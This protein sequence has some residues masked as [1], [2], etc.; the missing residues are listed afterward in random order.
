MKY[1]NTLLH[2]GDYNPGQ[3]LDSPEILEED[4]RLMKQAG[5]NAMTLAIFDWERLEPE[6]GRYEFDWLEAIIEN[7]YRQGIS[8][9]LATPS[10]ARPGWMAQKYPEVLRVNP[11][12]RRI[13]FSQRHNHCYTSPVYREKVQAMNRA[14]A[15]RFGRHPAV[16]LWHLSNE[17]GGECHCPLCQAAFREWLKKKYGTLEALNHA[18][19]NSFWSHSYS[20]WEQIS[21]P[22][23]GIGEHS[24]HTLVLDWK[25]FV[26]DQTVD[27][28][29]AEAAALR[30]YS[31]DVPITTNMMG[32][33]DGLNYGKFRD[34]CDVISWDNYPHWHNG[35]EGEAASIAMA[36][37]LMRSLKPDR[38]FLMM[39]SSPSA[40]NWE[41]VA[42]LRRPGMHMLSSLQAV[43]HGSDSVQYFQWRKCRGGFEKFHGAVVGHDG[44]AGTRVFRDVQQVGE[45]LGR[46]SQL[47]GARFPARAALLC[48]MEN[49]WIL[50]QIKGLIN[51]QPEKGFL[52]DLKAMYRPFFRNGVN[53]DVVDM[54][55]DLT[56]YQLVAAPMLYL[57]RAGIAGKLRRF[58]EEGGVLV[59]TYWSGVADE[60]D[61]CFLGGAPGQGLDE[62]FGLRAEEIDALYPQDSNQVQLLPGKGLPGM[63][64]SY[65]A[66]ELCEL[67]NLTTAQPL[68]V[69]GQDFY[70]GRPA[71]TVN[72]FG[73]GRAYYICSR[74]SQDFLDDFLGALIRE[75]GLRAID[76]ELPAQVTVNVRENRETG[77]PYYFVQ[78]F[79]DSPA[80]VKLPQGFADLESGAPCPGVLELEPYSLRILT[81]AE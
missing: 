58:V 39:E 62:V 1:W 42:K 9:V 37:D 24:H 7:L 26:T 25:R 57:L 74:N 36:H 27:F 77:Q 47:C 20:D 15:Q 16:I 70:Q 51:S 3:W 75:L 60:N 81:K 14:L 13:L 56:P 28:M 8:T 68:A 22:M 44:T 34:V 6:E 79:G 64:E 71:L 17:Y 29:R 50:D 67:V 63:K 69:Y 10:G 11:D 52:G 48:D 32:F 46:L 35:E 55:A 43:A 4:L 31:P 12:G 80:Q 38:P 76:T 2:G 73:K 5:C 19:W 23:E 30:Q 53:V 21:S 78:N 66:R 65:Q 49:R 33:Y 59:G 40:T 54:E 72:R 18:Y 41:P 61:L 45:R